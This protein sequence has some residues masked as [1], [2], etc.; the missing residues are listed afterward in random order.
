MVTDVDDETPT[1]AL[2]MSETELSGLL[3][4]CVVVGTVAWT[5]TGSTALG[6]RLATFVLSVLAAAAVYV[7][8]TRRLGG[9]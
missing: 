1:V 9:A 4:V 7:P 6:T 8:V 5:N 3:A 2:G